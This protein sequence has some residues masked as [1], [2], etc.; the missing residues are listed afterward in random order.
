[1][2]QGC[3]DLGDPGYDTDFGHGLV[4]ARYSVE[5]ALP[6]RIWV[7][8]AWGGFEIG[9]FFAPY[10]TLSEAVNAV[11]NGGTIAIRAGSTSA[12]LTINKPVTIVSWKGAA[13]IGQ[14]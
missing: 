9:S 13:V 5:A 1:M 10:N 12:T 11:P 8:F 2:Q 7:N 6:D 14:N 3:V 4:N